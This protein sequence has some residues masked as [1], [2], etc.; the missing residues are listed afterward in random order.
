MDSQTFVE[1]LKVASPVIS[2]ATVVIGGVI[3]IIKAIRSIRSENAQDRKL[4][5]ERLS[6][7]ERKICE[8]NTKV[9]SIEKHLSEKKERR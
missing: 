8:T 3:A 6:N 4:S 5:D 2:S 1:I 7:L 9:K